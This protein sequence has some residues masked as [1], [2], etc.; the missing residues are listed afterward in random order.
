[1]GL[2]TN[3]EFLFWQ[4]F[5]FKLPPVF[6]RSWVISKRSNHIFWSIFRTKVSCWRY[7]QK[8]SPQTCNLDSSINGSDTN[9]KRT[10]YIFSRVL[11]HHFWLDSQ[12][13]NVLLKTKSFYLARGHVIEAIELI[14]LLVASSAAGEYSEGNCIKMGLPG[15]LI[16][17]KRKG[18]LEVIFSW[19]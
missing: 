3:L 18:L 12:W 6:L 10:W 1:M 11:S 8:V 9:L 17:S 13:M 4:E 5:D 7:L 19:K 16:L 15:K 14:F 2:G